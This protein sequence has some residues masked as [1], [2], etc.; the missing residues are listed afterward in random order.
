M[1]LHLG[2]PIRPDELVHHR[3]GDR[4]DNRIENLELW[5][6]AHPRGQRV[7]DNVTFCIE[8]LHRYLVE[9]VSERSRL[10]Q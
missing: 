8:M 9:T 4:S 3:N 2:R 10:S 7:E 6:T 5:T 1:A